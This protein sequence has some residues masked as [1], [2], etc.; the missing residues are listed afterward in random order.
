MYESVGWGEWG[1]IEVLVEVVLVVVDYLLYRDSVQWNWIDKDT[2]VY[3]NEKMLYDIK[4]I[5]TV[6]G[7]NVCEIDYIKE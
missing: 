2:E 4:V 5:L 1:V 3:K 6:L 7:V